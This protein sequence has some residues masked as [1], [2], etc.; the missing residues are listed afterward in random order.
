M[1]PNEMIE[2]SLLNTFLFYISVMGVFLIIGVFLRLKIR[3]LKKFFI[4]ASLIAGF[5]G[6]IL[7]PFGLKLLSEEMVS[8]WGSLSSIL[9]TIVF[10]P[11]LIG[12]KTEKRKETSKLVTQ[13][14][15]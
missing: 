5:L 12:M 7:G 1:I 10:A 13:H 8:S 15:L 6:L 4:P 9:I 2:S 11:M 3:I 14:L